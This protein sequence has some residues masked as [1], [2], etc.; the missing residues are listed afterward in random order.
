MAFRSVDE[1]DNLV[2]IKVVGVGGAGNN[3][4]NRM[5]QDDVKSVEFIAINTDKQ[6]LDANLAP[7][8]ILLGDKVTGGRGAGANPEV[9]RR[10]AED[11]RDLISE[12]LKDAEMV[13][14]T[15]GMGG[16]TGTGAAPLVA[17]IAKEMGVLTVGIVTK[18]FGFEGNRKMKQAEKGIADLGAHVD[19][20]VVIP[21][22]RLKYITEERITLANAF[23]VAD[24]VLKQG[25]QS[26]TDLI[27]GHGVLNLDFADVCAVLRDAGYAHMCVASAKG[28]DKAEEV[29]R[30]VITS[31]LL[32]TSVSGAK[33]VM[34]NFTAD[35]EV[36]LEDIY[37]AADIIREEADDDA[38]IIW[39][40]V[41]DDE[42]QDELRATVIAT[43]FAQPPAP[44]Q[45]PQK[46]VMKPLS[47]V[48]YTFKSVTDPAAPVV[49]AA[50]VATPAVKPTSDLTSFLNPDEEAPAAPAAAASEGDGDSDEDFMRLLDEITRGK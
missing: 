47:S 46:P 27:K 38:N 15:A 43:G 3:A 23:T 41:L 33:G 4:L 22:E 21:N 6:D 5:I 30:K 26:I 34:I 19:S 17:E 37:R 36:A 7:S 48:G 25:V 50:P 39:G 8:K 42:L 14:I 32:E 35:P 13:F 18:P 31:P 16:G 40:I 45:A 2:T 44:S 29:A 28:K 49:P 10:A 9:G 20:L 11:S 12:A 24:S 1:T